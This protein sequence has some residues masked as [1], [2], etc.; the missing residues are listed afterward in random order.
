MNAARAIHIACFA[1]LTLCAASARAHAEEW[2]S[3]SPDPIVTIDQPTSGQ[4]Q[5]AVCNGGQISL[6]ANVSDFDSLSEECTGPQ[7]YPDSPTTITHWTCSGGTITGTSPKYWTS[8]ITPGQ[9]TVT[10]FGDDVRTGSDPRNDAE[11]SAEKTVWAVGVALQYYSSGEQS[12]AHTASGTTTV[13][14]HA[15]T[16]QTVWFRAIN[17]PSSAPAWPTG[18]P[19]GVGPTGTAVAVTGGDPISLSSECGN[20]VTANVIQHV[21]EVAGLQ[22][23]VDGGPL[24]DIEETWPPTFVLKWSTVTLHAKPNPANATWPDGSLMWRVGQEDGVWFQ[25]NGSLSWQ[26]D[27]VST[28][29]WDTINYI[30]VKKGNGQPICAPIVVCSIVGMSACIVQPDEPWYPYYVYGPNGPRSDNPNDWVWVCPSGTSVWFLATYF[31]DNQYF[32]VQGTYS[33]SAGGNAV[34]VTPADVDPQWAEFLFPAPCPDTTPFAVT[35]QTVVQEVSCD[36]YVHDPINFEITSPKGSMDAN[37]NPQNCWLPSPA[38]RFDFQGVT[39]GS[40]G[41]YNLT[42]SGTATPVPPFGILWTL[43]PAAGTLANETSATP[44]HSSP[45]AAGDGTLTLGA[46]FRG[47][48]SFP[49]TPS[50]IRLVDSRKVKIYQDHLERDI[51]NFG[52][53]GYCAP[54]SPATYWEVTAFNVNPPV[55]L[56]ETWNCHA[57]TRHAYNA[58]YSQ[59]FT[60]QPW[61]SWTPKIVVTVTHSQDGNGTHP[62]LGNLSRGDVVAYFSP[63]GRPYNPPNIADRSLWTMQHS[64]T[65]TGN[66]TETYGAN[67]V[68][69]TY[70]GAPGQGQSWT[71]ATSTVGDWANHIWQPTLQGDYVPFIIVVFEKP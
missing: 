16:G 30:E 66:G 68:P 7:L 15:Y 6:H 10:A 17:Q 8:P 18:K 45:A 21:P 69:K 42:I 27:S 28:T 26:F 20:T 64:Q 60:D 39:S 47:S 31:P 19:V 12:W 62:S 54:V 9:Y 38:A 33:W 51:A 14:V 36:V 50:D 56:T 53:G 23:Q 71:W 41:A 48:T 35:V 29:M 5:C 40:P 4:A 70:P 11:G 25:G 63:I 57:S 43:E 58:T 55:Q 32:N 65:C 52:T 34:D 2:W 3:A 59:S 44:T 67:N 1:V 22:Y 49:W 24:N 13:P 37:P 46:T 61:L